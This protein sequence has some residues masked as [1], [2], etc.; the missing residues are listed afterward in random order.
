MTTPLTRRGGLIG[1]L[2]IAFFLFAGTVY[3]ADPVPVGPLDIGG[4]FAAL[5]SNVLGNTTLQAIVL[6]TLADFVLGSVKALSNGTW[7]AKWLDAWVGDHLAKV[8][9]IIF[10]L[11]FGIVAPP[12][13]IGDF[14]LNV[15]GAAAET[16]ALAYLIKTGVSVAGNFNFSS[17]DPPPASVTIAP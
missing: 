16:A 7:K 10:G 5:G 13:V 4:L 15:V 11:L 9:T 6:I 17:A 3:A 8:V 14:S 2:A 12:I 1:L